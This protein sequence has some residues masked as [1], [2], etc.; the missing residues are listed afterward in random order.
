M[1]R[2]HP[3]ILLL[4][5]GA[6]LATSLASAAD[7]RRRSSSSSNRTEAP[8]TSATPNGSNPGFE[9]FQIIAE[10]NIFNPNRVGRTRNVAEEKPPRFDEISLVGT[11]QSD[12]G[13]MAFFN[14]PDPAFSKALREG[15]T[16]ADF[17]IK[18][19]AADR[20]ELLQGEKTLT[21]RVTEQLRR[22]EGG[23]WSVR[24][25]PTTA[26]A[27]AGTARPAEATI[28]EIPADA[29][30]VLKRLMKNREKQLK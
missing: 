20:V 3:L 14:S 22:P 6:V 18:N 23:E 11:L 13:V 8:K 7:E 24:A 26:A 2:F 25:S 30:D 29:S 5:T 12:R 10:R 15:E 28:T 21:L 1:T 17:K 19:I 9:P 16:I 27:A 4:A